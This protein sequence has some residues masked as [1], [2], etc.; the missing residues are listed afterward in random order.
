MFHFC[1]S[2]NLLYI[3]V[4]HHPVKKKK[5]NRAFGFHPGGLGTAEGPPLQTAAAHDENV[6]YDAQF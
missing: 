5:K 6:V 3:F 4:T 1:S 2:T